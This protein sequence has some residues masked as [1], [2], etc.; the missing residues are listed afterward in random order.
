MQVFEENFSKAMQEAFERGHSV[1]V[2]SPDEEDSQENEQ[3]TL[4]D[5]I[6]SSIHNTLTTLEESTIGITHVTL[7]VADKDREMVSFPSVT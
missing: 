1:M 5:V 7:A 4:A 6:L 3:E 2:L